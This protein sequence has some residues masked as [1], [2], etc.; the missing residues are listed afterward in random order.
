MTDTNTKDKSF[1]VTSDTMDY[2]PERKPVAPFVGK[3]VDWK[4]RTQGFTNEDGSVTEHR[5]LRIYWDP[6][7]AVA[8]W[9]DG[10]YFSE[11]R[12]SKRI[13]SAYGCIMHWFDEAIEATTGVT[14]AKFTDPDQ[15]KGMVF[16]VGE[17]KPSDAFWDKTYI[18]KKG[19]VYPHVRAENRERMTRT[20]MVVLGVAP[21]GW[22]KSI[23]SN[24]QQLKLEAMQKAASRKADREAAAGGGSSGSSATSATVIPSFTE[25]NTFSW[26]EGD[27]ERAVVEFLDG[28]SET[29]NVVLLAMQ[30]SALKEAVGLR[31]QDVVFGLGNKGVQ[32]ALVARGLLSIDSEGVYRGA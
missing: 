9:E 10:L 19:N 4:T 12:I 17:A 7:N 2:A 24:L 13:D 25:T 1:I 15:L 14:G 29:D 6:Q 30:D 21:V 3:F 23:P 11:W 16:L 22:E 27:I 26:L 20:P 18:D 8:P 31:H 32:S 28:K 5:Y